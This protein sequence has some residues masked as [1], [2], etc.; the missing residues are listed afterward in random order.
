MLAAVAAWVQLDD[1]PFPITTP[2]AVA[3]GLRTLGYRFEATGSAKG[4][5]FLSRGGTAFRARM[6][7]GGTGKEGDHPERVWD[8]GLTLELAFPKELPNN[9]EEGG[10]RPN[11]LDWKTSVVS[12][13]GRTATIH[14]TLSLSE[15]PSYGTVRANLDGLWARGARFAERHKGRFVAAVEPDWS[16]V[17]LSDAL[18]LGR[19]DEPSLRRATASWGWKP[20]RSAAPPIWEPWSFGMRVEGTPLWLAL[21]F[22]GG[23]V[24][25][26]YVGGAC[27]LPPTLVASRWSDVAGND[28][29]R[30][31]FTSNERLRVYVGRTLD[32]RHGARLGDLRLRIEKIAGKLAALRRLPGATPVSK[33]SSQDR[34]PSGRARSDPSSDAVGRSA[35]DAGPIAPP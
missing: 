32:L 21:V 20:G 11:L 4:E 17:R 34:P 26:V 6:R 25:K 1:A 7:V 31:E 27:D 8:M 10:P 15:G 22:E 16:R 12:H 13:L 24:T 9:L 28:L 23:P 2:A 29:Y 33:P 3:S 19:P 5:G 30:A 14:S 18:V 35:K